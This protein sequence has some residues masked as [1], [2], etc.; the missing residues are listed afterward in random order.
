MEKRS[1]SR[2]DFLRISAGAAAGSVLAACAQAPQVVE[3]EKEVTREVEKVVEKQVET[4]VTATPPPQ[5]PVNIRF[6]ATAPEQYYNIDA[7][8]E[9]HPLINCEFEDIG[10]EGFDAVVLTSVAS[11]NPPELAWAS[12]SKLWRFAQSG[13]IDD[14]APLMEASPHH[15]I[16]LI[17]KT[18]VNQYNSPG[19]FPAG[20]VMMAPGQYGWPVYNTAWVMIYNRRIFDEAGADYPQKGWSWDDWRAAL[21][22]VHNPDKNAWG[23]GIPSGPGSTP[24]FVH[25]LLWTN[26]GDVYGP[27]GKCALASPE[28]VESLKFVQDLVLEDK[29]AILSGSAEGVGFLSGNMALEYWGMWIIGWYDGGLED[30]YGIAPLPVKKDEAVWGGIDGFTFLKGA[31]NPWAGWELAKWM[32]S[33]EWPDGGPGG[34]K[35]I[36]DEDSVE[37]LSV[38]SKALAGAYVNP[39]FGIPEGS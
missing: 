22:Q 35:V 7:F 16:D 6:I 31:A 27:D 37:V 18:A 39:N 30:K 2:R 9:Q 24:T 19:F 1:F 4:V 14:I 32:T 34:M 17:D 38:N 29:T 3:V 20:Q 10:D 36:N 21:Q 15:E 5:E 26:G 23:F 33:F 28:A 12:G 11:G 13:A 8:S 25:S